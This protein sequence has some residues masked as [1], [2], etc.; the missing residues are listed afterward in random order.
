MWLADFLPE[1]DGMCNT[2]IM[3]YGYNSQLVKDT[4]DMQLVDYRKELIQLLE[5]ARPSRQ[6]RD[7]WCDNRSARPMPFFIARHA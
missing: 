4:V 6:V 2:R 3:T 5:T 1:E 7:S